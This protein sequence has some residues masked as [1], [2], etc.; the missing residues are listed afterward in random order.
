MAS[1]A[2][3]TYLDFLKTNQMKITMAA[4]ITATTNTGTITAGTTTLGSIDDC[5]LLVA[6]QRGGGGGGEGI[7]VVHALNTNGRL[8]WYYIGV[9]RRH[10]D[11]CGEEAFR[12]VW[13]GGIQTGVGKRHSDRCGEEAFRQV[14]GGGIKLRAVEGCQ[15]DLLDGTV[16]GGRRG[17]GDKEVKVSKPL[18]YGQKVALTERSHS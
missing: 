12:Q 18:P 3:C 17:S 6:V 9:E 8:T 4:A 2:Y 1:I 16:G 5:M 10:P 15:S 7:S 11:R 13:G 14:W